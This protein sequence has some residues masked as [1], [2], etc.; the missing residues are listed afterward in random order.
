M[1]NFI[2]W[3]F[4]VECCRSFLQT[5]TVRDKKLV[6]ATWSVYKYDA[7][8]TTDINKARAAARMTGGVVKRFNKLTGDVI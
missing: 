5:V 3:Y 1:E 8:K 6:S 4:I 7:W 2:D